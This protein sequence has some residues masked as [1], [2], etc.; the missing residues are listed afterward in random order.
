MRERTGFCIGVKEYFRDVVDHL[1]RVNAQVD[2]MR[3]TIVT[4][5]QVNLAMATI[6]ES[7][8]TKRLAAWAAIFARLHRAGGRVGHEL[9]AYARAAVEVRLCR[10]VGDD[11]RQLCLVVLAIQARTLV[12]MA[13]DSDIRPDPDQ[14]LEQLRADESRQRRGRLRIYFGASAGVGKT[15][16]MLSAAQR[17]RRG[18]P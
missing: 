4:A 5:I 2:T 7:E 6:E 8:V 13:I 14:L 17:E 12:V 16:A 15:Y 1:A 11:R 9:R 3:D 18:R 10:R